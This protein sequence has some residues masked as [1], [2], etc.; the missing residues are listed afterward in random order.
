MGWFRR[1]RLSPMPVA[2]SLDELNDRIREWEVQDDGRRINDRIRTIGQDFAAE[3]PFLAL[4]PAEVFDPDLMLTPRVDRSSMVTVRM[5][6]YS[7]PARFIGRKVR[8]SLRASE[9]VVF[10]GRAVAARHPRI[11]AKCG[12]SVQLDHYLEVLKTKPGALPGSTALARARE[13]GAFTSAHEAFWAASRRVND[14]A[15]GTRELIDVLLLHRSMDASDVQA[16]ITA[17]LGVGAVSADVVAVEARRHATVASGG[18]SGSDRHPGAHDE[19]NVQRVVSLTQRRIMDPSVRRAAGQTHRTPRRN[20]V[21]GEH[22]MSPTAPA[23]TI[24]PTLRRRRDLTEQAAVAAV[25]QA[26]RRLRLPTVRA[27]LDE[28]LTV[29]GKEQLSYQGFLR[30]LLAECDDRDRRSSIRRVKAANFPRDKWLGDFD[31]DANPNINPATIHTLATGDWIRKG[32]PLCLIG[33]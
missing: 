33:D 10:D 12:Q 8:V 18:G 32:A 31:F 20:S 24:T 30:E 5:V 17:A 1:N 22:L 25:D 21:E 6:K 19:V 23:T 29:A 7:V 15:D 3:Q 28:A 9:V 14:D 2:G 11:V 26:C 16:G 27:V 13:S 4:L